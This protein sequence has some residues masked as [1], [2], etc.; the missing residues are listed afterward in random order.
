MKKNYLDTQEQLGKINKLDDYEVLGELLASEFWISYL[1]KKKTVA[2]KK[3]PLRKQLST[4]LTMKIYD[5]SK[6]ANDEGLL[7]FVIRESF[8]S[9]KA[10]T[11]Y[12]PNLLKIFTTDTELVMVFSFYEGLLLN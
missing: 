11:P 3:Q 2:Q 12:T 5:K 10:A 4:L 9:Q 7:Y 8:N 1:A 6:L